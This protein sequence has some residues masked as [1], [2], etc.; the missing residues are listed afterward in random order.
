[1]VLRKV[2]QKADEMMVEKEMT[3]VRTTKSRRVV[4]GCGKD[5]DFEMRRF[6]HGFDVSDRAMGYKSLQHGRHR[7]GFRVREDWMARS[8]G[9]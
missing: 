9:V 5:F 4:V 8:Q 6:D 1:M 3:G 2:P 7:L